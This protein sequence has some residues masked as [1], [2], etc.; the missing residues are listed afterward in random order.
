MEIKELIEKLFGDQ[1]STETVEIDNWLIYSLPKGYA[2]TMRLETLF[3]EFALF[4]HNNLGQ[5]LIIAKDHYVIITYPKREQVDGKITL[6]LRDDHLRPVF[7]NDMSEESS[8]EANRVAPKLR[9]GYVWREQVALEDKDQVLPLW[10]ECLIALKEMHRFE[11]FEADNKSWH[12]IESTM[13]NKQDMIPQIRSSFKPFTIVET[14]DG[15]LYTLPAGFVALDKYRNFTI[16][17]DYEVAY[18][19]LEVFQAAHQ[20][21]KEYIELLLEVLSS[22]VFE[23]DE[24]YMAFKRADLE[25]ALLSAIGNSI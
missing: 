5:Q 10:K 8:F 3:K 1:P 19:K 12:F 9:F 7:L 13:L 6:A 2:T 16:A 15:V 23:S 21:D 24:E 18:G 25:T 20:G 11:S 4:G 17:I 22:P 14:E